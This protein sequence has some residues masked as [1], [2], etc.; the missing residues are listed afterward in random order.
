MASKEGEGGGG[1]W[2]N[3][4]KGT[5]SGRRRHHRQQACFPPQY[6]KVLYLPTLLRGAVNGTGSL[7]LSES[8]RVELLNVKYAAIN[9]KLE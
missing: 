7:F 8:M 3:C 1:R 6:L 5:K 9:V 4:H 2:G